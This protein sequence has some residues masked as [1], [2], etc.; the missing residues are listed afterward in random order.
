MLLFVSYSTK[1]QILRKIT[2][3]ILEIVIIPNKS[4]SLLKNKTNQYL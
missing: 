1:V 4:L 3:V 2:I